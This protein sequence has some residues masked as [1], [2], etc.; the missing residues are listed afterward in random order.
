MGLILKNQSFT[1]QI[2]ISWPTPELFMI[3]MPFCPD[4]C[5]AYDSLDF[6]S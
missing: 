2:K 4:C 5:E 3:A 6:I 1:K